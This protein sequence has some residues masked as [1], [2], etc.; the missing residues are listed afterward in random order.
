MDLEAFAKFLVPLATAGVAAAL[1][2]PAVTKTWD[3][4]RHLRRDRRKRESEFATKFAEQCGDENVARYA[5]ELGYAALVGDTNLSIE[6]R[7]VLLSLHDSERTINRFLRTQHWI[8]PYVSQR[9]LGWKRPR[10]EGR[11]YKAAAQAG[12]MVGY[13]GWAYFAGMPVL[14][15]DVSPLKTAP[16]SVVAVA[17]VWTILC[18]APLAVICMRRF[19]LLREAAQLVAEQRVFDGKRTECKFEAHRARSSN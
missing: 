5:E 14:L 1:Q 19:F 17:L 9:R 15:R 16:S 8:T 6:E 12:Y 7:K 4:L 11:A 2:L 3:D 10:H 13:V 18:G